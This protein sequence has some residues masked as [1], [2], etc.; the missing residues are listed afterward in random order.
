MN[1]RGP[2]AGTTNVRRNDAWTL[3]GVVLA[4]L[5]LEALVICAAVVRTGL[6]Y[7]SLNVPGAAQWDNIQFLWVAG[8]LPVQVA[9]I[10]PLLALVYRRRPSVALKCAIVAIA[11]LGTID[12]MLFCFVFLS[13]LLFLFPPFG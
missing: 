9:I 2:V 3:I 10:A 6:T 4:A 7:V 5:A 1:L 8:A 12:Q 13:L 11:V